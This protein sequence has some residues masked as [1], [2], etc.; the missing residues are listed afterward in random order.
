MIA[1]TGYENKDASGL[2]ELAEPWL[3]ENTTP[4]F[5]RELWRRLV[6]ADEHKHFQDFV[7][8]LEK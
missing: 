6:A 5:R 4:E 7:E 8:T 1:P 2:W 3:V